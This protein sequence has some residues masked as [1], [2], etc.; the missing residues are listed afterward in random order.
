L[1]QFPH[2]VALPPALYVPTAQGVQVPPERY[3]PALHVT[4]QFV[5]VVPGP[6]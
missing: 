6:V 5:A 3:A 2:A 1:V 4:G